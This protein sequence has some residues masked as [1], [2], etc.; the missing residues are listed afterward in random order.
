[1]CKKIIITI[2]LFCLAFSLCYNVAYAGLWA[3]E[4]G[5]GLDNPFG[6]TDSFTKVATK[7]ITWIRDIAILVAVGMIIWAGILFMTAAGSPD[8]I[9]KARNALLWALVGLAIVIIGTG[10]IELIQSFF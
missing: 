4:G 1:M 5:T 6:K 8:K 7:I 10:W 9:T 3:P 2:F